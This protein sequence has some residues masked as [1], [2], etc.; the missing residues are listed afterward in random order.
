MTGRFASIATQGTALLAAIWAGLVVGVSFI[1]TPVK[2]SAPTLELA[3]AIDVGRVTFALL[4]QIEWWLAGLTLI[5]A[6]LAHRAVFRLI[7]VGLAVAVVLF[8]TFW[9]LPI[10]DARSVAFVAGEPLP[11]SFHHAVF[12]VV[13]SLKVLAL[14]FAAIAYGRAGRP[15][16]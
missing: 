7:L 1:A 14:F 16:R 11:P 3:P 4:N 9:L 10:L 2:F 13:E 5:L 12:G 15:S 6:L 8:Q